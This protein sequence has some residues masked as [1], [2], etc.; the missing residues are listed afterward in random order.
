M[1]SAEDAVP[2]SQFYVCLSK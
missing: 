1:F 2:F